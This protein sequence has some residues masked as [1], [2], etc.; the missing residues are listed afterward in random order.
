MVQ[1]TSTRTGDDITPEFSGIY[2]GKF[3]DDTVG[4]AITASNQNRN[5]GVNAASTGGWFTRTGDDAS[6]VVNDASQVPIA[7]KSASEFLLHSAID[8]LQHC[9]V[10][11]RTNQRPSRSCSGRRRMT[12]SQRL[13]TSTPTSRWSALTAT[14]LLGSRTPTRCHKRANGITPAFT[15]PQPIYSEVVNNADFAMGT[16]ED[17]RENTNDSIGLNIEWAVN[18]RLMLAVD[19]HDS[20]AETGA[21]GGNGT[22]SLVT[23]ASF[24]KVGQSLITGSDMPIMVLNL[25]SGGEANR[26][27]YASDMIITGSTFGNDA[28]YMDIEQAKV[29]GTFD[30]TDSSSIDFGV[31]L[32]EVSNRSVSSNVQLDNW[33]G[34]TRPGD[35]ADVVVRSSID[36]QFDEL[37]GSDHPELQTEFFSASLADLQAVGEA[38]YAAEGL[39]YATTGDCGTGYCASTDWGND[40]RTTEESFAA[41]IQLNWSGDVSGMPANLRAGV[42][43]EETDVTSAAKSVLY[44]RTMWL[45]PGEEVL[46]LPA[47]DADGNL[48]QGFEDITASYD[49]L[50]PNIDFDIEIMESRRGHEARIVEPL[51]GTSS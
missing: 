35:L 20:S 9:R 10:R 44:D 22:S 42:R 27:L 36:G 37:S 15:T 48:L 16:G 13:T 41:Y 11:I 47:E 30:F 5:N 49:L 8:G 24:N 25:N 23:M 28:A 18:D 19:Y 39:D 14:C 6:I 50:L 3:A 1:D 33:G 31:Q 26:P 4:I 21:I 46:V 43:Y 12:S 29:S 45:A 32:T 7:R 40:I 17:G 2:I 51:L 34:L 38:H